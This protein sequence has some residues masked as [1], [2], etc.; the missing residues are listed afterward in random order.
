MPD[1]QLNTYKFEYVASSSVEL[2]SPVEVLDGNG[3]TKLQYEFV[4]GAVYETYD[5]SAVV[6]LT[7][8][9]DFRFVNDPVSE[10]KSTPAVKNKPGIEDK[11]EENLGDKVSD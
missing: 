1:T 2:A 11:K 5:Y 4:R 6:S 9:N 10:P 7:A 3:G 8:S